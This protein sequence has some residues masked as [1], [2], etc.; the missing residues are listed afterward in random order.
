MSA[1]KALLL[2]SSIAVPAVA[3]ASILSPA[4]PIWPAAIGLMAFVGVLVAGVMNPRLEMFA[5]VVCRSATGRSEVALTFDDGPSPSSTPKVLDALSHFGA[6]ATFFLLGAKAEAHPDL[7]KAIHAA[8]H[9]IGLHG[10][11]HDRLLSIR[12]PRQIGSD[13]ERAGTVIES[14]TGQ[15]PHLFRP[16]VGHVSPRTAVAARRLHLTLVGW[17]I[18]ARDGL[19]GTSAASVAKRVLGQLG[20]GAIVLLHDASER[21]D[22]EPAGVAALTGILAEAHRRGLACVTVSEAMEATVA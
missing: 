21:E 14:I 12:H 6:R 2:A 16:P 10:F 22:F 13:L 18:R 9:E 5:P 1:G 20:P 19:R 7:V 3:A 11:T 17:T 8:G 15:R 4:A